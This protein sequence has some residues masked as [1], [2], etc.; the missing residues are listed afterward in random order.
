MVF[1][2][3]NDRVRAHTA[4]GVNWKLDSRSRDSGMVSAS[5]GFSDPRR[6]AQHRG[7]SS[8]SCQMLARGR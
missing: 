8:N 5:F 2:Q 6:F 7:M 4:A 1:L 3:E